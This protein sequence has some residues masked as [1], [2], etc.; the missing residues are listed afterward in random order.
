MYIR[1]Y[2]SSDNNFA[3]KTLKAFAKEVLLYISSF[4][5]TWWAAGA[6]SRLCCLLPSTREALDKSD[7]SVTQA[8]ESCR[9]L[10]RCLRTAE[11]AA[12]PQ[13]YFVGSARSPTH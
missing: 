11:A 10:R 2:A 5:G 7:S 3:V 13:T 9:A 6:S 4:M 1:R 8:L 12:L